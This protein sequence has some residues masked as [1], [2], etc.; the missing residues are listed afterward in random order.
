[1][2]NRT[3][4]FSVEM[5]SVHEKLNA[6]EEFRRRRFRLLFCSPIVRIAATFCTNGQ[7]TV[8]TP[9]ASRDIRHSAPDRPSGSHGVAARCRARS[10]RQST[11]TTRDKERTMGR[12]WADRRL[13]GLNGKE[14][15]SGDV[16]PRLRRWR[17]DP[18]LGARAGWRDGSSQVGMCH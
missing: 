1:M 11:S 16:L 12:G 15:I 5:S 2:T 6:H 3:G 4:R 10:C 17:A 8:S 7:E 18:Q 13:G 9:R 14:A